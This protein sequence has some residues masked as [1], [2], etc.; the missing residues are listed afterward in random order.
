M[1]EAQKVVAAYYE[2]FGRKEMK[3]LR[4]LLAADFTF[5]GSMM[6]FDSPD[7]FIKAMAELPFEATVEGSKFISEGNRVAHAFVWKMTAPAKASVPMCEVFE[8]AEGRIR[9]S[10]LFYDSKLF[11]SMGPGNQK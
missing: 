9:S 5:R 1:S 2:A 3:K 8:V 6:S 11:P 7:A 4:A 10:E